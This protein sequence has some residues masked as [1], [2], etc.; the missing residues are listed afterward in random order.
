MKDAN[1]QQIAYFY[2]EEVAADVD[3]V[4]V[5][6]PGVPDRDNIANCKACRGRY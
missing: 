2:F 4:V 3:E 6:R 5:T 1:G